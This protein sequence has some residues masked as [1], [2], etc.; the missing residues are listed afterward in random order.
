MR[1]MANEGHLRWPTITPYSLNKKELG[2]EVGGSL[3]LVSLEVTN[4]KGDETDQKSKPNWRELLFPSLFGTSSL[5]RRP[6]ITLPPAKIK[7]LGWE[8]G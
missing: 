8:V 3:L 4:R 7:E 1:W 2:W 6:T 5:L